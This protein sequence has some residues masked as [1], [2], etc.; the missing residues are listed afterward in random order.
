VIDDDQTYRWSRG[1]WNRDGNF[2]LA[3]AS[4]SCCFRSPLFWMVLI[5][6]ATVNYQHEENRQRWCS[7][8]WHE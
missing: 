7:V 4:R 5:F 6:M 3:N 1:S 8:V 2:N